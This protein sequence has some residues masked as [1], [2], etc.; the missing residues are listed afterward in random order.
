MA[1]LPLPHV[2]VTAPML[3]RQ[4]SFDVWEEILSGARLKMGKYSSLYEHHERP[5]KSVKCRS[6]NCKVAGGF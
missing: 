1:Q 6:V 2:T 4:L 3:D 5:H